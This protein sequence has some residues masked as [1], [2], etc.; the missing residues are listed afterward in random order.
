MSR[1]GV[2]SSWAIL[3]AIALGIWGGRTPALAG[4]DSRTVSRFLQ[5]LKNRG[6]HDLAL[7]YLNH[8]RNE[9][10]LPADLKVVLDYEEGRTLIDEAA[11]TGD[12]VLRKE[13]LEEARNKLD[14]FTKTHP[15]LPQA[16]DALV[17]LARLLVERG[18]LAMLQ[19]EDTA[20]KAKKDAKIAE[21]RASF[22]QAQQA[23]SQAVAQLS[24]AY[25]K[26]AG[27]IPEGPLRDERDSV[28]ATY[29]DAMLQQAVCEYELAQTHPAGSAERTKSLTSARD[30]F[31][32][33]YKSYREQLAGLAAQM[34]QAKCYEELGNI[35]AGIGIYKQLLEHGDARLRTLQRH[36]GYFNIV[37]LAKRKDYALAADEATRWLQKYS[38]RD[39]RR[40]KEGLGVLLEQ[41]KSIDAQ[42]TE[43]SGAERPRAVKL[44]I[45]DLNQVVRF[46]SPFKGEAIALLKKYK[47]SAA[48]KADEIARLPFEDVMA[49]GDEAIAAHEWERAISL[50]KVAIRKAD[51]L[52]DSDKL[53]LARYNLA[54]CYYMNKQYYE[55]D[56]LA[57]H[58]ARR[59]PQGGLSPKATAI[60]MQSLA[61][62]YNAYTE[63]DRLSDI[64][65]LMDLAR[66][67]AATWP[68]RE[69]GDDAR[70]NLGQICQGR[71]QNDK[72]IEAFASIRK[73]SAKWLEA[74]TRLG[75][76]HWAKSRALERQGDAAGAPSEAKK[77][78]E[79]LKAS[80]QARSEGGAGPTDPGLMG[81]A[82]DL[83]IVL[84]ETGK[85]AE[86][87]ALLD[88]IVK[89]QSVRTGPAYARLAEA[90]LMA[91]ITS[92]QV[93]QAISAMKSLEEA[94]GGTNLT[95]LYLKLGK[96]LEQELESLR[97]KKNSKAFDQMQ[98]S[99]RSFLTTLAASQTGQTYESLYWAG[100]R[101]L[102]LDSPKDAE[103]VLRRVLSEF[104]EKPEFLQQKG[105]PGRL[106]IAK[107]KLAAALRDQRKFEE[108]N[109]LM[110][111]LLDQKPP[112]LDVLVEKGMLLEAEA[113]AGKGS[114]SSAL[115]HWEGLAKRLGA[116][117]AR[118]R[119]REY[120]DVWYHVALVLDKQK[121]ADKARQTLLGVM[122]LSPTVGD[123]EMK[124]KYQ[125]LLARLQAK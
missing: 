68:E 36:V 85:P 87:L 37:A 83:A 21:A 90:Q 88:P 34:W 40:S 74:Q 51:P 47:P 38:Q 26:F 123:S 119:P 100:E 95:Q 39:E 17:Q 62:A 55:A 66:Y 1:R 97:Q 23:Y 92:N 54:F 125:G 29:L 76:A 57:E 116:S 98:Q 53:N 18:H 77:A 33:M 31:E 49:R 42:M 109:S 14:A 59:Y 96:L 5:E 20:D 7:D 48:V 113:E 71:G 52:R 4:E 2:P 13:L 67:T 103:G 112:Y 61:D 63:V 8:L 120:F 60:G 41:A 82:G 84:T 9:P 46:A 117:R 6:L 81:N 102:T 115:A 89:A 86:A 30:Q 16:R 70:M 28:Y 43:I 111:E 72:A 56:I 75:S 19:A 44:I 24:A 64:E 27:F 121:Q 12:L 45:D 122:K 118:P 80:L 101:L 79:I 11:R 50:L 65:R 22:V 73:R 25:K 69:E 105:G 104:A 15:Q 94:G 35:G 91:Y 108:A 107:V 114:W 124:A 58:L 110:E 99:Y 3:T 32:G 93:P 10:A 106:I 78:I